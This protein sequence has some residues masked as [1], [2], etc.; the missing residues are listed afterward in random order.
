MPARVV[1]A[2]AAKSTP[3]LKPRSSGPPGPF[4]H[5]AASASPVASALRKLR[6]SAI[7]ANNSGRA[8]NTPPPLW[9]VLRQ[10]EDD[11]RRLQR[12]HRR[13]HPLQRP[14]RALAHRRRAVNLAALALAAGAVFVLNERFFL[15]ACSRPARI[16]LC[17]V[18]PPAPISLLT[19]GVSTLAERRCRPVF[20][21][22]FHV[23]F[24]GRQ[25]HSER[26]SRYLA[27]SPSHW[28]ST[29]WCTCGNFQI[30]LVVLKHRHGPVSLLPPLRASTRFAANLGRVNFLD[31]PKS[32]VEIG[33]SEA[34]FET[35]LHGRR[36]LRWQRSPRAG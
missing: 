12:T 4:P 13:R 31:S 7:G 5:T 3:G 14:G 29:G 32:L 17:S 8:N 27:A 21:M 34:R 19:S 20:P 30:L 15:N 2:R 1:S 18:L 24:H 25:R 35:Q 9:N 6:A 26:M 23:S 16:A 33:S 28:Q 11:G 10:V 36:C 22:Q